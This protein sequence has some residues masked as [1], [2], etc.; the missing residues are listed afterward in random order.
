[1]KFTAQEIN[2]IL[3]KAIDS[4]L[5]NGAAQPEAG[6]DANN[7]R[8]VTIEKNLGVLSSQLSKLVELSATGFEKPKSVEDVVADMGKSLEAKFTAL[9]TKAVKPEEAAAS[10]P[11]PQTKGE[12]QK[13]MTDTIMEILEKKVKKTEPPKGKG[14]DNLEKDNAN[15]NEEEV[16]IDSQIEKTDKN[17]NALTK[18]QRLA[19]QNLDTF[20]G[21]MISGNKNA[22]DADTDDDADAAAAEDAEIEIE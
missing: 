6:A 22:S 9:L 21:K 19:R 1:M 7:N 17:G 8:I 14:K 20:L 5:S 11:I 16:I 10:E 18:E 3:G 4:A 12:F 15:G 2:S 13:M